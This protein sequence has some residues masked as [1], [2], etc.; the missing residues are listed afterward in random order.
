MT[1]ISE[2]EDGAFPETRSVGFESDSAGSD[3]SGSYEEEGILY[4]VQTY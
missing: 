4:L 1:E 3:T 2:Y